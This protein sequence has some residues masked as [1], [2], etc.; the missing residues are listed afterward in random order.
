MSNQS[1]NTMSDECTRSI[2]SRPCRRARRSSSEL[3]GHKYPLGA[4]VMYQTPYSSTWYPGTIITQLQ[5]PKS[6]FIENNDGKMVRHTEQHMR[7]YVARRTHVPRPHA[8]G[9]NCSAISD[10]SSSPNHQET[11]TPSPVPIQTSNTIKELI[12]NLIT[13][14]SRL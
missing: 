5:E 9:R 11:T 1:L 3:T 14:R 7:P 8:F 13:R 2:I 12:V 10:R 4:H 6:Y